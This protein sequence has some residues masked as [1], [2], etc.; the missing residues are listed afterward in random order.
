MPEYINPNYIALF[1]W[2]FHKAQNKYSQKRLAIHADVSR[3][4]SNF[5][6]NSFKGF[7]YTH[8]VF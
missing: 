4:P 7:T 8:A 6:G 1:S 5:R 2:Y 3:F